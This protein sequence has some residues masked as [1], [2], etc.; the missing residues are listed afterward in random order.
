MVGS[1]HRTRLWGRSVGRWPS[2]TGA[3]SRPSRTKKLVWSGAA[4]S[5][6]DGP[7]RSHPSARGPRLSVVVSLLACR[8]RL[9][10]DATSTVSTVIGGPAPSDRLAPT[11]CPRARAGSSATG[12][13]GWWTHNTQ[14]RAGLSSRAE[15]ERRSSFRGSRLEAPRAPRRRSGGGLFVCC[16][17]GRACGWEVVDGRGWAQ[18]GPPDRR[19]RPCFRVLRAATDAKL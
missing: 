7:P 8:A 16:R 10:V 19:A 12:G 3:L 2:R 14:G 11:D 17:A 5:T 6:A 1:G 18:H 15:A 4:F 13:R 9:P